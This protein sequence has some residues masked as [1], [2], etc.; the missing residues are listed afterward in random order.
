MGSMSSPKPSCS[1][2]R[3]SSL[4]SY[5]QAL[6]RAQ[7]AAQCT[8]ACASSASSFHSNCQSPASDLDTW[9]GRWLDT[10]MHLQACM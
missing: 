4:H 2:F 10:K 3:L 9:S 8:L 7:E 1:G 6:Q 5:W